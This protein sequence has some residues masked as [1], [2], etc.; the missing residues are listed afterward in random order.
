[1]E[2]VL[3]HQRSKFLSSCPHVIRSTDSFASTRV[4]RMCTWNSTGNDTYRFPCLSLGL[5][6]KPCIHF[7]HADTKNNYVVVTRVC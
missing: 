5:H 1:M 7:A 6:P 2:S 3:Y 4:I